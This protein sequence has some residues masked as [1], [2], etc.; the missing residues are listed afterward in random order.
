MYPRTDVN[1]LERNISPG[2]KLRFVNWLELQNKCE[3]GYTGWRFRDGLFKGK[4]RGF[5][6]TLPP[7]SQS[8]T[9]CTYK[10]NIEAHSCDHNCRGKAIRVTYSE[11][12]SATL[13]NQHAKSMRRNYVVT[14]VFPAV[15]RSSTLSHKGYDFLRIGGGLLNILVCFEFPYKSVR[16]IYHS[17]LISTRLNH[18]CTCL[19]VKVK[20]KCTLVQAQR[21]CTG[22]TVHRGS[23]GIA[24]LYRHWGS[25]QA[26]RPIGGV[27]V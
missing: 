12:V 8:H 24:V 9:R 22:R 14:L 20:V 15:P 3:N 19:H 17:K 16:N 27:E 11:R 21:I 6:A 10:R 13:S 2:M 23:R 7:E 4:C 5:A 26:V 18:N 25:V 1:P